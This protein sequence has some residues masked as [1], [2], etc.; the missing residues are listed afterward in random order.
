MSTAGI[1]LLLAEHLISITA[2]KQIENNNNEIH[3]V[4]V[5]SMELFV[6]H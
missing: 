1:V 5:A 4:P 6:T 3:L 2:H